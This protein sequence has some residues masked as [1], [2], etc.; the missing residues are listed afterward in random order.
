MDLPV[1]KVETIFQVLGDYIYYSII[2]LC[3]WRSAKIA[4]QA[5]KVATLMH[6]VLR[7]FW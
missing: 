3:T 4:D 5:G 7:E 6:Q 2:F 1:K